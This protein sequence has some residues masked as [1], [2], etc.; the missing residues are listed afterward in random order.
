MEQLTNST[1][2][3]THF[4]QHRLLPVLQKKYNGIKHMIIDDEEIIRKGFIP[5]NLVNYHILAC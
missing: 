1:I 5:T 3:N 2:V 4:F